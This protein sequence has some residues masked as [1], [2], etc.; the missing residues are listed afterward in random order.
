M[1]K[2]NSKL[3][4][5]GQPFYIGLD[6]HLRNW[7]VTIRN[8]D[9]TLKTFSMDPRPDLLLSHLNRNY[10]GGKYFSVYE[11]GFCGFWIHRALND[12]GIENIV[13]NPA[14]V[15]TTHKEKHRRRD[16]VDSSKLSR[17]L[18]N[19]SLKPIYVPDLFHEELRSLCR[20]YHRC[21]SHQTR[22]KNRIRSFL[23]RHNVQIP[24][25]TEVFPWSGRFITWLSFLSFE[26][27]TAQTN[28]HFCLDELQSE[29]NRIKD[30]LKTLRLISRKPPIKK[31]IHDYLMSVLGVGFITA[32][33]FYSEIMDIHRFSSFDKLAA[34]VGL[35]PDVDASG[36]RETTTG[37]TFRQN[38]YLRHM[39]IESAWIAARLDPAMTLKFSELAKK[40]KKQQAIIRIAKKLLSR[41]RH[42]WINETSY[43]KAIVY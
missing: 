26:A 11:A 33:T 20:L 3:N 19:Q 22:L 6:V 18:A 38:Q 10:P 28:L 39:L 4:F 27:E 40:M 29:R 13:I 8:N 35:V 21:V 25:R 36:D 41:M 7:A 9:L 12:M 37:L 34:F 2:Q 23:Y 5:K 14:D 15:P 1:Q 32:I 16:P 30:I 42:V 43:V 24:P 31:I 17:E